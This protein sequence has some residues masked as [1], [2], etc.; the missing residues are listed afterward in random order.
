MAKIDLK[1]IK[2]ADLLKDMAMHEETLRKARF[3]VAGTVGLKDNHKTLRKKI[4]QIK[5]EL[6]RRAK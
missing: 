6:T 2:D 4:A 1:E 5:T 3:K